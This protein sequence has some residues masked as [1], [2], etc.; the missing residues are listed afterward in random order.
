M[1]KLA[2]AIRTTAAD[3]RTAPSKKYSYEAW[4]QFTRLIRFSWESKTEVEQEES[5]EGMIE[6]DWIGDDSPMLADKGEPEWVLDKLCDSLDRF[7]RRNYGPDGNANN[8]TTQTTRQDEDEDEG[9]RGVDGR[10]I[11][12]ESSSG[13]SG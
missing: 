3:V 1:L 5:E 4:V 7:I 8:A 12:R 6:W 11:N 13:S 2:G 10:D 9:A